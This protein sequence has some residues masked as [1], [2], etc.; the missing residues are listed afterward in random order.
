MK[1]IGSILDGN[2][3][4]GPGFDTMRLLL[5]ISILCWH[6]IAISYG[7]DMDAAVRRTTLNAG[8]N[9]LLPVFFALSGFLVMASAMRAQSLRKFVVLRGLRI[10][11]ALATEITL[12][13]LLIGST[14]TVLPWHEY[15]ASHQFFAYFGS[16]F[17]R[18]RTVL[19]GVFQDNP[20]PGLVN[21]SL[22]TI[23]SELI[24]YVYLAALIVS[25]VVRH[26]RLVT[27]FACAFIL[28]DFCRDQFGA[29]HH[30]ATQALLGRS[31]L[32]S[33]MLGNLAYLW[34]DKLP[35]RWPAF[36]A[37]LAIGLGL[38]DSVYWEDV[39]LVALTYC[40]VFLGVT[41]IKKIPVLSRGDYSYGIYLYAFA[42]QQAVT[43]LLPGARQFYW[44]ILISLPLVILLAMG[45]WRFVEEPTLALRK[46]LTSQPNRVGSRLSARDLLSTFLSLVLLLAYGA[47]LSANAR[48][49][50]PEYGLHSANGFLTLGGVIVA[51]ALLTALRRALSQTEPAVLVSQPSLSL[52]FKE[53][54]ASKS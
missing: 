49:L 24:C 33:F 9:A 37:S 54:T 50:P 12:S 17:G 46:R 1:S 13:A 45:S 6:S 3:G 36:F 16:L 22:W 41:P 53:A 20:L 51:A 15:F 11:P 47:Y 5:S 44:N 43:Q 35:Y 40:T 8:A 25:G 4:I 10:L 14:L 52:A 19:P 23:G 26:R 48:I 18:I 42:I 28:L 32:V 21:A 31:L 34:R 27:A 7:V 29:D 38:V 30:L 39:G 2:K